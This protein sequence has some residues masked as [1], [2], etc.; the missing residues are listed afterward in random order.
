MS[1]FNAVVN[2]TTDKT[3]VGGI[4]ESYQYIPME[5]AVIDEESGE[6]TGDKVLKMVRV[7]FVAW[8]GHTVPF[9]H[10]ELSENLEFD[11]VYVGSID[12]DDREE[13]ETNASIVALLE[14]NYP[15]I[16][17]QL[18]AEVEA[19]EDEEEE[20]GHDDELHAHGNEVN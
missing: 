7:N 5:V 17:E 2:H 8:P 3:K 12:E 6:P 19:D 11:N 1:T 18:R 10:E 20:D 16:A 13:A 9:L 15:E 4:V 14:D